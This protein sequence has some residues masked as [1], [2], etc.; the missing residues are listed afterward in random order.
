M[1]RTTLS[2]C[3]L[4]GTLL[5]ATMAV[6]RQGQEALKPVERAP[7]LAPAHPDSLPASESVRRDTLV[8]PALARA[9][10]TATHVSLAVALDERRVERQSADVPGGD[11]E[12]AL[13]ELLLD[14]PRPASEAS[15]QVLTSRPNELREQAQTTLARRN[16]LRFVPESEADLAAETVADDESPVAA[17]LAPDT[18]PDLQLDS[19]R[20]WGPEMLTL[21]NEIRTCLNHYYHEVEDVNERSPWG[22][23]HA[24]IAYGV[25]TQ[26]RAGG[27]NVNAIGWLCWNQPCRG[28]RL[29]SAPNGRLSTQNGPG[30]QGHEGQFLAMLAQSRVPIDFE[31]RVDGHR[32]TV[33]DLVEFE[34][35]TCRPN[36]ELTFKLIGLSHYLES[37]A[38]WVNDRGERWDIPRLIQEELR[39]PVIGAACGGTHRMMGF[40]Y[41]VRKR[42]Q[43]DEPVEG[44]WLR[45]RKYVDSYHDYTLK[46]QNPDGS[47]STDWFRSRA[48]SPDLARRVQTTGHIL[49]WLVYSLPE[50]QLTDPRVVRGIQYLTRLMLQHRSWEVGP[51]GHA[52]HA[53]VLYDERVFGGWLDGP[54][55]VAE[56]IEAEMLEAAEGVATQPA[57]G[58][59]DEAGQRSAETQ[60]RRSRGLFNLGR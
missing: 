13:F 3:L 8:V 53:L 40:S 38:Q 52:L 56:Q 60:V 23:M 10:S 5:A 34:Q 24:L 41:A 49:E 36:S 11:D 21:R 6:H 43:R 59:R 18:A 15:E 32:F 1:I 16:S 55:Q 27:R 46:L 7:R 30:V 45:A 39:Q 42:E 58:V 25:H 35:R 14:D 29:F 28:Q 50:D 48:N 17:E 20:Q 33:A 4:F 54:P 12:D 22:I 2:C 47:F 19:D 51:K 31:L 57:P 44:Q 9:S 26:V 37:D